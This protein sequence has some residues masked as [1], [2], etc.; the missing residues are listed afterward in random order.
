MPGIQGADGKNILK[1][2][3]LSH[4]GRECVV[5]TVALRQLSQRWDYQPIHKSGKTRTAVL[6]TTKSE[7]L[8]ERR[9]YVTKTF[10]ADATT[11]S[12]LIKFMTKIKDK[13][14]L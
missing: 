5:N 3:L 13:L 9:W 10:K 4:A 7:R 14:P 6:I 11:V 1:H 8:G 12:S 2:Q